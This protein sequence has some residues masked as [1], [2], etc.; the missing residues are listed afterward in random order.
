MIRG[1]GALLMT[2]G[3][4]ILL[5]VVHSVVA[6]DSANQE[7]QADLDRQLRADWADSSVMHPAALE[8]TSGVPRGSAIAVVHIPRLGADYQRV[9]LEG[10]DEAELAQGPG[11]YPGTAM[12]GQ[13]GNVA[14]AGHR[15]GQGSPFLDIDQLR[16]GDPIVLETA[17]SWFV[18]RVLGDPASGNF[19]ADPSGIPGKQIVP[20]DRIEVISPVPNGSPHAA[21]GGSYLTLTTCHPR[22]SDR[23]RLILHAALDGSATSKAEDPDGPPALR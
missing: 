16:P 23:Q 17:G 15:V 8:S 14:L 11:H 19:A 9:V 13:R 2:A 4:G 3:L 7:H 6:G 21:P 22:F 5:C 18:Y 10:T 1:A 12:P 20:P